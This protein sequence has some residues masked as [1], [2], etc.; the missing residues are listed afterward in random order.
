MNRVTI[1]L[2]SSLYLIGFVFFS[3]SSP[4]AEQVD[5]NR[6]V[7]PILAKHCVAC[8]GPDE[9]ARE[10][11]LRLDIDDEQL[12]PF[13]TRES[14]QVIVAGNPDESLL[15]QR[16]NSDDEDLVMPP[17]GDEHPRLETSEKKML[18]EW[19]IQG[20]EFAGHWAFTKD[21]PPIIRQRV[22]NL[23]QENAVDAFV[24]DALDTINQKP[25]K[26]A[27]KRTL[28]RRL[29]LDLTGLPPSREEI[30]A[31]LNDE[32]ENAY[33]ALVDRLLASPAYGEHMARYWLD[34]VRF[35]DTNGIH[36]DHYREMTPYR[37]WVI[38]SFNSNLPFD[39]F[40]KWQIAGDLF[41]SPT[42]DQLIASGFNRLHLV[43][44]RGT[45]IPQES[46][47]RNVIDRVN[48]FGTAFLGLTVGCAVC[49][50]HKYDPITQK[51]FYQL[52]AFFNNIDSTP[53]T[54][55]RN[56]H[57]PFIRLT[58]K[59]EEKQLRSME[60]ELA[61]LTKEKSALSTKIKSLSGKP[62]ED[63]SDSKEKEGLSQQLAK[64]EAAIK[65]AKQ[66]KDTLEKS[67]PVS[68][69]MKERKEIRPANILI[70]GAYDQL[71]E[72]VER[73]T[74]AFLPP[75]QRTGDVASRMDL[76]SWLLQP[77]HPL[78]AR[79]TVNR[80]WQQ[81]FGVGLVK[82]SE[83][84]GTQGELPSHPELLNKLSSDFVANGWDVKSLV[85]RIV[86]SKT[87]RQSSQ[88]NQDQFE[89]DS[90][91]RNLARGSR[92]RL[93]AEIIRDQILMTAGLL[94][95]SM[96]G[97]SVKP[98]QP[99]NLWKNVSMVSSSTYAFKADEGEKIH[100]RSLYSFWK[101]ALP[102]PQMTIFDAPTREACVARRERTNTP[103]QALVLMNETRYFQAA[104]QLATRLFESESDPAARI[105][106][107]FE[108]ITSHLPS[109]TEFESLKSGL[110]TLETSYKEDPEAVRELL[111]LPSEVTPTN[112]DQSVAAF[113]MLVNAIYN[114]DRVKTRE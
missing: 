92:F 55:G 18:R 113:T 78:T 106:V 68:L 81:F 112:H 51:D 97:K 7:R 63:G 84:F 101:R 15:W 41:P 26:A 40:V 105:N 111:E 33:T 99:P 19:I 62:E 102:P 64:I 90:E 87:Y 47:T 73:N 43:I 83:D 80:I 89:L 6:H 17:L 61:D 70:R 104:R 72:E 91:N 30:A 37:D 79:V 8:H 16:I 75:L 74:P 69:I 42:R 56:T 59:S 67:I 10:A 98:P 107:A 54:P 38:R 21:N 34:L 36:H 85:R 82:T 12:G 35:A 13:A 65:T 110:L 108:T 25:N 11:E 44:D 45:A 109:Q 71:G 9:A 29:T 53:E 27:T 4:A 57:P 93:D 20:G 32:S 22:D 103:L 58:S 86:L 3:H 88:A 76:A 49:H 31:Y 23:W 2:L 48:A 1:P 5:F 94:N 50:D 66:R 114:L 46:F 95:G 100:R 28:I 52:Y 60:Q 96:F 14:G 77:E 24:L 39:D